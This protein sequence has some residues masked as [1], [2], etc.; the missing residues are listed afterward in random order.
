MA[1]KT[2]PEQTQTSSHLFICILLQGIWAVVGPHPCWR[3]LMNMQ[4][5]DIKAKGGKK[6]LPQNEF[7]AGIDGIN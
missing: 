4:W 2:Q 3:S 1:T 6:S 5:I 7:L